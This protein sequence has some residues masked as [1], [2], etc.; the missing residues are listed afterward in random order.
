MAGVDDG[1]Q[2][3]ARLEW[4][5]EDVVDLVVDNVAGGLVVDGDEGLVVTVVFVAVEVL[6][7]ASVSCTRLAPV[8]P[9][10]C[11]VTHLNNAGR[12]SHWA[13]RRLQANASR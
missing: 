6:G 3:H 2:A 10:P 4:A 5:D 11:R 13:S 9:S 12:A 8:P 1:G 7:L